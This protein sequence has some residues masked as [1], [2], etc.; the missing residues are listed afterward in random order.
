MI[1]SI[2]SLDQTSTAQY[3]NFYIETFA[4]PVSVGY[5]GLPPLGNL[6]L[7][8]VSTIGSFNGLQ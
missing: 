2:L 5:R 4:E 7:D 6:P 3:G 8:I 1:T